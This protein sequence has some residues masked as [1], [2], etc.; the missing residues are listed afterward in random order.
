MDIG[1]SSFIA[2]RRDGKLVF[3]GVLFLPQERRCSGELLGRPEKDHPLQIRAMYELRQILP[4]AEW[5]Q[6]R[7]LIIGG[8]RGQEDE[9]LV[10]ARPQ[11]SHLKIKAVLVRLSFSQIAILRNRFRSA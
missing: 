1:Q 3:F 6:V 9:R 11:Y 10:Q 2:L 5:D 4:E 8:C 7:L